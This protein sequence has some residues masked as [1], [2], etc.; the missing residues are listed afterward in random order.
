MIPDPGTLPGGDFAVPGAVRLEIIDRESSLGFWRDLI[1]LEVRE[2]TPDAISLGTSQDTLL[3]LHPVA[4]VPAQR[5]YAGLYHVAIHLPDEAQFA[6]VLARLIERNV[7]ISP[8]DHTFSKAIYLS[9][10]DALGVELTLETPER[11]IDVSVGPS[12]PSILDASGR[13]LSLAEP[14][15][16]R[17][18]LAHL[19]DGATDSP[20][21]P[22]ARIG[23][24]HLHVHELEIARRFYQE[25][26][27]F[28]EHFGIPG[29]VSNLHS[30]GVFPHRL[31]INC[32]SGSGLPHPP[33]GM[34][35]LRSYTIRYDTPQRLNAVLRGLPE[36]TE[37][38]DG[39]L[40][41][42]PSG[43]AIILTV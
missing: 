35:R 41:Y 18:V 14:L 3:V 36:A 1:G 2:D 13:R 26:L 28:L 21:H 27:G 23:H 25:R 15:D 30:G 33:P 42:D 40:V 6:V 17:G 9:D 7:P 4:T 34:A 39:E 10:P 16:I 5:G 20:L 32:F 24:V 8:A 31:A 38:A 29:I 19:P 37:H 12:G 11:G 43:H 22:A